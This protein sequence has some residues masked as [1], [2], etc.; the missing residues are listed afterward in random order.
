MQ[1]ASAERAYRRYVGKA[2]GATFGMVADRLRP[3]STRTHANMQPM[4][5]KAS[6]GTG[7][8]RQSYS[9]FTGMTTG[10]GPLYLGVAAAPGGIFNAYLQ[11]GR[12][13]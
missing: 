6:S 11:P 4:P 7:A 13:F 9:V 1:R 8:L 2:T 3:P 5:S 12:P 10:F